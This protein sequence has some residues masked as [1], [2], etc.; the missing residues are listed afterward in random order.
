MQNYITIGANYL[1]SD[2]A[3]GHL[4]AKATEQQSAY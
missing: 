3:R 4:R 1:V 2:L